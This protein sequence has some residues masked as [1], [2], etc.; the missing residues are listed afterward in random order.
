MTFG[1]GIWVRKV[2]VS[3][4]VP[5]MELKDQFTT[6]VQPLI[7]VAMGMFRE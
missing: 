3:F 6:A 4:L 7:Q 1:S 5:S 2:R